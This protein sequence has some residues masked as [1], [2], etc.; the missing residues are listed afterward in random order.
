MCIRDSPYTDLT[1]TFYMSQESILHFLCYYN[2]FDF[3]KIFFNC[4]ELK[5]VHININAKSSSKNTPL[6]DFCLGPNELS[7]D[8]LKL[9][10]S[11]GADI[12]HLNDFGCTPLMVLFSSF[13]NKQSRNQIF[14]YMLNNGADPNIGEGNSSY[15]LELLCNRKDYSAIDILI[16]SDTLSEKSILHSRSLFNK[17]VEIIK[18]LG[19]LD[20]YQLLDKE[21]DI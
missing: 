15:L 7:L 18:I 20:N 16:K 21:P 13:R 1:Q 2:N 3:A 10:I 9:L 5:G 8:F 17:N 4:A 12:N 6:I 19:G 11:K 14:E